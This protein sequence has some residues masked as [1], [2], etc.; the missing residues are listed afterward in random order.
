MKT[1]WTFAPLMPVN[2]RTP[3]AVGVVRCA[4]CKQTA[5]LGDMMLQEVIPGAKTRFERAT[6]RMIH[7]PEDDCPAQPRPE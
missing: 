3:P 6:L 4:L 7:A 2:S 5:K 1:R